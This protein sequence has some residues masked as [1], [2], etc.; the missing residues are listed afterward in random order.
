VLHFFEERAE[1]IDTTTL[2]FEWDMGDGSRYRGLEADHC[3]ED[4]GTY[5]VR[6]DVVDIITGEVQSNV[7]YYNFTIP[8]IEQP[9]IT[10]QIQF[11]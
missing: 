5:T 2:Y 3:F 10:A 11:M 7:A 9:Y 1:V 8:R 4:I 6:L